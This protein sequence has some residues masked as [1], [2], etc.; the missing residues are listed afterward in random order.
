MQEEERQN[1]IP[2]ALKLK[3]NAAEMT[4]SVPKLQF[5]KRKNP[6][7]EPSSSTSIQHPPITFIG[8]AIQSQPQM[9]SQQIY[10]PTLSNQQTCDC[11]TDPD[12]VFLRS[13]LEDMKTMNR[14]NKGLFKIKVQ[15]ILQDILYPED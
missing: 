3:R 4:P 14:K 1:V 12:A 10:S 13:L 15:Q 6:L 9:T 2:K 11:T 5:L 8:P 7:M